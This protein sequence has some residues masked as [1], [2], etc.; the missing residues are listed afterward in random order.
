MKIET[1]AAAIRPI[2][3]IGL[4]P[5]AETDTLLLPTTPG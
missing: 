4:I 3:I 2:M 5:A 1:P